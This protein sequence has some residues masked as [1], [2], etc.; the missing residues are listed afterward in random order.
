MMNRFVIKTALFLSVI[1]TYAHPAPSL[2]IEGYVTANTFNR[3]IRISVIEKFTTVIKHSFG[4]SV[5]GEQA[6]RNN[7]FENS[8]FAGAEYR[9]GKKSLQVPIGLFAGINDLHIGQYA[10]V[11]PVVGGSSGIILRLSERSSLRVNYFGKVYFD[12]ETVF[13]NDVMIGFAYTFISR[14]RRP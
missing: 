14:D 2:E 12:T 1:A 5:F 11:I 3:S 8:I 7:S 6:L 13:G 10:A 9:F 4:V